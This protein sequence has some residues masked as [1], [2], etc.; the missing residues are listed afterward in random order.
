VA[1]WY[2]YR[3]I[4]RPEGYDKLASVGMFE[5]EGES[6][7]SVYFSRSWRLLRSGGVFLNHGI[8]RSISELKRTGLSFENTYFLPGGEL[9]P[10]STALR[11]VE[12][13]GFEVRAVEGL[14]EHYALTLRH[15]AHHLV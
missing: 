5:H 14:R 6:Q 2:N 10:S 15:W 7:L 3:E 11:V 13:G 1:F 4:E 12:T 8:S 9:L